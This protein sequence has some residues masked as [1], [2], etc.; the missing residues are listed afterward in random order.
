[1]EKN[2][3]VYC[4][5]SPAGKRYVG[6]TSKKPSKRWQNGRGYKYNS[7]FFTAIK[8]Y[9]WDNFQHIILQ[10]NLTREEAS[11]EERR[12]IEEY[13]STNPEKGYNI[14]TGGAHGGHPTSEEAKA[15]ISKANKGRPCPEYQKRHLSKLNKGIIPTNLDD[16]HRKREK[17]VDQFDRDGNFIKTHPSMRKAARV[18]GINENS[19]ACCC[20][21]IYMTA[22]GFVWKYHEQG[23]SV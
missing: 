7:H 8:K 22:G 17:P 6:V 16:L 19:V 9:G 12:L 2:Y 21:G 10:E 14:S 11:E 4:H 5:V 3:C 15:K 13:E 20:R 18:L 1:M 23:G